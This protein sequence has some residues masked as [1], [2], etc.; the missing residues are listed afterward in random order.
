MIVLN[1]NLPVLPERVFE[2]AARS[3][4]SYRV[5][6]TIED[7][8][9]PDDFS[10]ER[11]NVKV[12]GPTMTITLKGILAGTV[13]ALPVNPSLTRVEITSNGKDEEFFP[14]M[15]EISNRLKEFIRGPRKDDFGSTDWTAL[16]EKDKLTKTEKLCIRYV[17]REKFPFQ[18]MKAFLAEASNV[19]P[20]LTFTPRQFYLLLQKAKTRNLIT[21]NAQNRWILANSN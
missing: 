12:Y 13:M 9:I 5:R 17:T 14:V 11:T 2:L 18:S 3:V 4:I 21:K 7:D 1:E 10:P 20:E 19:D 15:Q 8:F 16:V 6:N